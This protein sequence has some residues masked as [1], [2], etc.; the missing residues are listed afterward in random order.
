MV[1]SKNVLSGC[2]FVVGSER[3]FVSWQV[4]LVFVD[5]FAVFVGDDGLDVFVAFGDLDGRTIQWFAGESAH[6]GISYLFAWQHLFHHRYV[7]NVK[8]AVVCVSSW[9][10]CGFNDVDTCRQRI[11]CYRV[12]K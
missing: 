6:H 2:R 7:C 11:D 1:V 5:G 3:I 12:V 4:L 10:R 9:L 8:H